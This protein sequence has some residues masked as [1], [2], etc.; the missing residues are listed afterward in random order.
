MPLSVFSFRCLS[1]LFFYLLKQLAQAFKEKH[2]YMYS[3]MPCSFLTLIL[4]FHSPCRP[5]HF[6]V[7]LM[8]VMPSSILSTSKSYAY[9]FK[10][11][12]SPLFSHVISLT[13][14]FFSTSHPLSWFLSLIPPQLFLVFP[15]LNFPLIFP[16]C[17]SLLVLTHSLLHFFPFSS[18]CPFRNSLCS[19][20]HLS[21]TSH[22]TLGLC[23]CCY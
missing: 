22:G 7:A 12:F 16:L 6:S 1:F 4:L 2:L 20:F 17:C 14:F 18:L 13:L 9:Y 21:S 8:F 3:C 15:L 11:S 5:H 23:C 10:S 19:F